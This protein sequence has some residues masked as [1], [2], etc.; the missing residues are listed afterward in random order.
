MHF[1]RTSIITLFQPLEQTICFRYEVPF[2]LHAHTYAR[3]GSRSLED[4]VC[5]IITVLHFTA[6]HVS[7][8]PC[9]RSPISCTYNSH[10][11]DH[12]CAYIGS[13]CFVFSEDTSLADLETGDILR[14]F[15]WVIPT[16]V[17][18]CMSQC[19]VDQAYLFPNSISQRRCGRVR[20]IFIRG[21]P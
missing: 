11:P 6:H 14:R 5:P 21:L 4:V 16:S 19:A 7:A 12:S 20:S 8:V 17:S 13:T 15:C 1:T 18:N 9:L 2:I 10:A 3:A